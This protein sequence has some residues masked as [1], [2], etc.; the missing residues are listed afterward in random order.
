M[1]QFLNGVV[2]TLEIVEESIQGFVEK[3]LKAIAAIESK[4]KR[5]QSIIAMIDEFLEKL[6]GFKFDFD[7]PANILMHMA[8][9]TDDLMTKLCTADNKP[10]TQGPETKSFGLLL[11]GGGIPSILVELIMS[12]FPTPEET[13]AAVE[14]EE[15]MVE[16]T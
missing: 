5:I 2:N 1:E 14:A 8:N 4:I 10:V 16:I 12:L 7:V 9:G 13:A 6:K 15:N 11:V 3:I